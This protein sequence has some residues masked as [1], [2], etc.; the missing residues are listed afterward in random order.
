M[1]GSKPLGTPQTEK[2]GFNLLSETNDI[3]EYIHFISNS[4]L[5]ITISTE[6]CIWSAYLAPPVHVILLLDLPEDGSHK[7]QQQETAIKT[8]IHC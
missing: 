4:K 3:Q 8:E 1:T 6:T 5:R 2:G 7:K